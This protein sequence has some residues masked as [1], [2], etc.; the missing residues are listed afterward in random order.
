MPINRVPPIEKAVEGNQSDVCFLRC[1]TES[2]RFIR[3][4]DPGLELAPGTA[5]G[6]NFDIRDGPSPVRGRKSRSELL[7]IGCSH[8][9]IRSDDVLLR[10]SL[11]AKIARQNQ[12][13]VKERLRMG[14]VWHGFRLQVHRKF[15]LQSVISSPHALQR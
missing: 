6:W 13:T 14:V 2:Q 4:L 15:Q 5:E 3:R 10:E 12:R 11:A 1:C 9:K 7:C 8:T